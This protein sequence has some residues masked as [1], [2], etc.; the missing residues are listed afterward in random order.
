MPMVLFGC[1]KDCFPNEGVQEHCAQNVS[2]QISRLLG[3]PAEAVKVHYFPVTQEI[4]PFVKI[5]F[6]DSGAELNQMAVEEIQSA[7]SESLRQGSSYGYEVYI[8][9]KKHAWRGGK[10]WQ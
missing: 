1:Q 4:K 2:A 6:F 7:I 3:I 5:T 9:D 10:K 8:L